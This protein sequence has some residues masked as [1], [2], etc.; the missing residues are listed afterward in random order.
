MTAEAIQTV[1]LR[2]RDLA[3]APGGTLG[4][5]KQICTDH[6]HVW[7]GWWSK[8]G[9]RV[10]Q[11][12]FGRL[13]KLANQPGGL[14][15]WLFDSGRELFF[16]ATCIDIRWEATAEEIKSPEPDKTPAYYR[17]R[18]WLAWFKLVSVSTVPEGDPTSILHGYSYVQVDEFFDHGRSRFTVFYGKQV[19][20]LQELREQDRTIWFV[21]P[22]DASADP[23]HQILLLDARTTSPT[24][25]PEEFRQTAG[26]SI[27]WLSDVHFSKAGHHAFPPVTSE[28][29]APLATRVEQAC[30]HHKVTDLGGIVLSG[31]LSWECAQEEFD[32]AARMIRFLLSS[33]AL[34]N[35]HVGVCP[36]NHDLAFS[37]KPFKKDAPVVRVD[38]AA[39]HGYERF[40]SD[41]FYLYPNEFLSCGRRYLLGGSMPVE[42]V[43]LNSS[44]LLQKK[45]RFQ[46]HGF[47]GE[48]QLEH[49]AKEM[50]WNTPADGPLPIRVAVIHHHLVPVIYRE[51][52]LSGRIYSVVLDAEAIVRWLLRNRVQ[53]VLHGH[54]HTPFYSEVRRPV[55]FGDHLETARPLHVF[56][57]GSSGV[58][59]SHLGEERRNVF[60][61]LTFDRA[62]VTVRYFTVHPTEP[63]REIASYHVAL[64][65]Y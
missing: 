63:S 43:Y 15:L 28:H 7:W 4:T 9:E 58:E 49:A 14:R 29:A 44:F 50:G 3:T 18:T 52:P 31:D 53:I 34:E 27:L 65:S 47:V 23:S 62:A 48:P 42:V 11:E 36:G 55:T 45:D 8:M 16:T 13:K 40:Y 2:F 59:V 56:G 1:I 12:V 54:M 57:M 64:G 10:P 30:R 17:E 35:Y 38:A 33:A 19:S 26:R 51:P 41:L 24:H 21:R 39:R 22:F 60:A 25:F 61:V 32:E 46:G 5:H 6:G 20:S 37:D